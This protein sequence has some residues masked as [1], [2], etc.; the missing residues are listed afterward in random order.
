MHYF[1]SE[2]DESK[3]ES[4]RLRGRKFIFTV[5]H[6]TR[7]VNRLACFTI[8]I[9]FIERLWILNHFFFFIFSALTHKKTNIY[10]YTYRNKCRLKLNERKTKKKIINVRE[11]RTHRYQAGRRHIHTR[12]DNKSARTYKII[13]CVVNSL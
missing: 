10:T 9:I 8:I 6:K 12:K 3:R 1:E 2:A 7:M 5:Q 4:E 11:D 13:Y